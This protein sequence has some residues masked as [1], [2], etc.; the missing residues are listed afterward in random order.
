MLL[1]LFAL[2]V[3]ALTPQPR[4]EAIDG[5]TEYRPNPIYSSTYVVSYHIPNPI[6]ISQPAA[7]AV[8]FNVSSL[9]GQTSEA[10]VHYVNITITTM[11]NQ[12]LF[13]RIINVGKEL[14]QGE[15]WGPQW[16]P[17][18]IGNSTLKLAPGTSTQV[19]VSISVSFDE[20]TV[21]SLIITSQ[22]SRT[23]QMANVPVQTILVQNPASVLT[24]RNQIDL[25]HAALTTFLV[26]A[27]V[28]IIMQMGDFLFSL[29]RP[30][31][32][33]PSGFR[34]PRTG[35]AMARWSSYRIFISLILAVLFIAIAQ[36]GAKDT[37]VNLLR[38]VSDI[39]LGRFD[40]EL[41]ATMF[42][43]IVGLLI[44]RH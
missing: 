39:F 19:H 3:P 9:V 15:I 21:I 11:D 40:F 43:W 18:S 26:G 34:N 25:S 13:A 1:V 14:K 2:S 41:Y 37:Q 28:Y 16:V 31:S 10:D 38:F 35:Q 32:S 44:R 4:P 5:S 29:P 12:V 36:L 33:L 20:V 27:I 23:P 7:L 22:K 30:D 8:S 42:L 24:Q 17:F 6:N